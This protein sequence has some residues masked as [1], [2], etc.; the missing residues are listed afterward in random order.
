MHWSATPACTCCGT[1]S[2]PP[3]R[4]GRT[5]LAK[6]LALAA[7]D[8][9]GLRD[10][11][12]H[13][14]GLDAFL[15]SLRTLEYALTARLLQARS[16]ADELRGDDARLRP[17]LA[18]FV[19]GTAPLMDAAAE[20]GETEARAFDGADA[21]LAFLRSRG[22]LAPM[23][24]ALSLSRAWPSSDDY[25]VAGRIPL[26]T[27]LDLVATFLET[28]DRLYRQRRRRRR[29]ARLLGPRLCRVAAGRTQRGQLKNWRMANGEWR[30]AVPFAMGPS[31]LAIRHWPF[32]PAPDHIGVIR[33]TTPWSRPM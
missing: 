24:P 6:E 23:P 20:L 8:G 29:P 9:P 13:T 2:T 7:P 27:L 26:G 11:L 16:R 10:W 22:L 14:R 28:L 32:A 30:M 12:R 17:F 5:L 1:T 21:E 33:L 25:Q 31:P 19:A 15:G 18:L 3:W 4:W